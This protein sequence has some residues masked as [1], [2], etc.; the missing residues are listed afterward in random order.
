MSR[1]EEDDAPYDYEWWDKLQHTR[2]RRLTL[3]QHLWIAAVA[4]GVALVGTPVALALGWLRWETPW[5]W[6]F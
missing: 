1:P 2:V 5:W 6:P 3:E 4:L